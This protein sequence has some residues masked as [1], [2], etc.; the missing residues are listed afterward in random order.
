MHEEDRV[1][2][3]VELALRQARLSLVRGRVRV[4][5]RGRVRVRAS[6]RVSVRVRVGLVGLRGLGL[7][8]VAR[9][10]EVHQ[11]GGLA[12]EARARCGGRRRLGGRLL[13]LGLG[14]G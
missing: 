14:L 3:A 1:L 10:R 5:V 8:G 4:R 6:V 2:E 7:S 12:L 13:G 11:H 9:R